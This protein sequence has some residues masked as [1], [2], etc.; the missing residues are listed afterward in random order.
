MVLTGPGGRRSV[1]FDRRVAA[2]VLVLGLT[3]AVLA[4]VGVGLGDYPLTPG[5]VIATLADRTDE[6]ARLIVVGMRLPRVLVAIMVGAS[7]GMAGA[8]FQSLAR[9]PLASP[10]IIGFGNG[11][12]TGAVV[13]ILL[14]SGSMLRVAI[15]AMAGGLV[16]AMT[17]YLLAYKRGVQGFRLVL[18][19]IGISS[20]LVSVNSWL[21]VRAELHEAQIARIWLL[22]SLNGR[23]W[24]HATAVFLGMVVL[25]PL[26]LAMTRPMKM[27]EMGDD[28]ASGLGIRPELTRGGLLLAATALTG[29]A[30]AVAGP[31]SFIALA[32]PQLARR[33]TR[34]AGV[35]VGAAGAMGAALLTAADLAAQHAFAT[36]L[37]VG[38]MTVSVGGAY[39]IWLLARERKAGRG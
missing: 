37:P 9:N 36:Q 38:V 31:I 3:T 2:T 21:L 27:L 35:A 25:V 19:G 32:A 13:T 17:V 14:L 8:V 28:M 12:A 1:R 10:D 29:L 15:G 26:L 11:A 24:D 6:R 7:L 22:G 18:V 39:L 33:L 30:T 4:V 34:S 5:E 20:M 16:T 23:G